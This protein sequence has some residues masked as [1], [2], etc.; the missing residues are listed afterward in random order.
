MKKNN[1]TRVY[2]CAWERLT[3]IM[4][5]SFTFVL[6]SSG[7]RQHIPSTRFFHD[8]GKWALV[9]IGFCVMAHGLGASAPNSSDEVFAPFILKENFDIRGPLFT[10]RDGTLFIAG[11]RARDTEGRTFSSFDNGWTWEYS[12]KAVPAKVLP[13]SGHILLDREGELHVLAKA[14][15][16]ADEKKTQATSEWEH[17]YTVH[18]RSEWRKSPNVVYRGDIRTS[19]GFIQHSNGTFIFPF[20]TGRGGR[21]GP[22]PYGSKTVKVLYSEDDGHSWNLSSD[23]LRAP[24]HKATETRGASEP[25]LIELNDGRVWMLMRSQSGYFYEAISRDAASWSLPWPSR[26]PTVNSNCQLLRLPDG[27]LMVFWNLGSFE[28]KETAVPR[29]P[30]RDALHAAISPDDGA[31]WYGF[32][33]IY[34]DPRAT[35]AQPSEGDRGAG[36]PR[37]TY[38]LNGKVVVHTGQ[39]TDRRALL[40][41]D[42]DWLMETEQY[43]DFS[44]GIDEWRTWKEFGAPANPGKE[45]FRPRKEGAVLVEHPEKNGAKSLRIARPIASEDPDGAVWNF[46]IGQQGTLSLRCQLQPGFKGAIIALS[47]RLYRPSF[48]RGIE[49]SVF[50]LFIPAE[51]LVNEK[52][53][54]SPGKWFDLVFDWD[55]SRKQCRV[56]L[57]GEPVKILHQKE[58]SSEATTAY[59][60]APETKNLPNILPMNVRP[61]GICYL[62]IQSSSPEPDERGILVESVRAELTKPGTYSMPLGQNALSNIR[63]PDQNSP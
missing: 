53:V 63:H 55:L 31:T 5:P 10:L 16:P 2:D 25:T 58:V 29:Y 43:T 59:H 51:G 45:R 30:N 41:F 49:Q 14:T 18:G 4:A 44:N 46:P 40:I 20:P 27:R 19:R 34:R 42:P 1:G 23:W 50:T 12:K 8:R 61:N 38:T 60:T 56:R 57:N 15:P 7:V 17:H 48:K 35:G 33:Q 26:F 13:P 62:H 11:P 47:D 54:A 28:V 24:V 36:Y 9:F 37:V 3:S 6:Q 52:R 32:R 21:G 39:M 22:L